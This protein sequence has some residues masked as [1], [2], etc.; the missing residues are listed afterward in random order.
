MTVSVWA[1]LECVLVFLYFV[2]VVALNLD[3]SVFNRV[4]VTGF[5]N[6]FSEGSELETLSGEYSVNLIP[7]DKNKLSV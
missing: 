6:Y 3:I 7:I 1:T 5:L 2:F 4:A